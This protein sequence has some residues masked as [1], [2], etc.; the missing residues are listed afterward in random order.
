MR[1]RNYF[2]VIAVL[3]IALALTACRSGIRMSQEELRSAAA[4][5]EFVPIDPMPFDT[6]SY[7]KSDGT[8][9]DDAPWPTIATKTIRTLLPNQ[10]ADMTTYKLTQSGEIKYLTAST[11]GEAGVY[12]VVM[13]YVQYRVEN[14]END[15]GK[16]IGVGR[17]GIGLRIKAQIQTKKAGIDLGSLIALGI[18]AKRGEIQGKLSVAALGVNS[19]EIT[20]L[21]PTPSDINETSIQKALEALAAIKSK[22]GDDATSL[23]PQVVAVKV[24]DASALAGSDVG[25]RLQ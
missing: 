24:T 21:F 23:T 19:P 2:K 11:T 18:A 17:V 12:R 14:I 8:K 13:D 7:V 16:Q 6:V 22:I 15:A 9:V 5:N 1:V 4:Y 25:N 10:Q 20:T 3:T